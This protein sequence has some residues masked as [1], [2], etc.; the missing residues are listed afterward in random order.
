MKRNHTCDEKITQVLGTDEWRTRVDA[1]GH[2]GVVFRETYAEQFRGIGFETAE[3]MEIKARRTN[4]PVYDLV[5]AS[6]DARGLDFWKK[7][8]M[9][10]PSGQRSLF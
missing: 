4:V 3:H 7:I 2:L 8:Q 9:I 10:A 6:R 5:F 1:G